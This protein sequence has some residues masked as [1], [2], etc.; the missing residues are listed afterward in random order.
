MSD[1]SVKTVLVNIFGG[2]LRC[3]VAARGFVM[4]AQEMPGSM[5]PM[6]V[7][8]LGTNSEE[9]RE[10]LSKSNLDISLVETLDDA[11]EKIVSAINEKI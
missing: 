1:S 3:D 10:I 9:G 4:A 6:V 2:I 7:R 11:A 5:R 8:M